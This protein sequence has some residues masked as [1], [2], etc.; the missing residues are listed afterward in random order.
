[1]TP[2][3][4][5]RELL[6]RSRDQMVLGSCAT[7]LEWDEDVTMPE[8]GAAHRAEQQAL[9]A[10][11][12]HAQATD[13]RLGE[14]L[15]RALEGEH[16]RDPVVRANLKALADEHE[17]ARLVPGSLV[18]E[19]ARVTT[20]S[21]DAWHLARESGDVRAYLPKL[22]R[23]LALKQ[24]EADCVARG[25]SRYDAMLDEWEEGLTWGELAPMLAR[26]SE[27]SRPLLARV[28]DRRP[29]S[30]LLAQ[31]VPAPVQD[32]IC[33][34]L[35]ADLGFDLTLGRLDTAVHPSTTRIGPGDVRLTTRYDE[36]AFTGG[37]F[38]T[39][40]E[41]GHGLYEQY[42]PEEHF[43]APVGEAPSLGMHESQARLL[44]NHLGR[45]RAFWRWLWPRA[46]PKIGGALGAAHADEIFEGIAA[47]NVGASRIRA[48]ELS[49]DLH[50]LVRAELERALVSGDLRVG[51]LPAAWNEA[52]A[53]TLD[54]RIG[55]DVE[56]CLSDGHWA[57][58]MFGYFPTYTIG[59]CIAAQLVATL[60]A[61]VGDLDAR[62]ERGDFA[63]LLSFLRERVHRWGSLY[64]TRTLVLR[65]TGAPL[66]VEPLIAHLRARADALA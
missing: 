55:S 18:E 36:D 2:E 52:Y 40:H 43:G 66:S 38:A 27:A 61:E 59:N 39:L 25:R 32:A 9:L 6:R 49:Y 28:R 37:L 45:S 15:A 1:M 35:A 10:R 19:L 30:V 4:A 65:A 17:E 44:E 11:L 13:E 26:L 29:P 64:D 22:E 58:G 62:I 60:R 12:G 47:V 14:L 23:V 51:D 33:Q 53:K 16:A 21:T 8:G 57:D 48:D 41:L 56:G 24:A 34:A 63:A 46:A 5:Y 20:L 54:V 7:L 42:L 50:I 3:E 31:R